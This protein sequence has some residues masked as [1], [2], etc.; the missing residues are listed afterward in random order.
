MLKL[1]DICKTYKSKKGAQFQRLF[2]YRFRLLPQY[3]RRIRISGIQ[4]SERIF[5]RG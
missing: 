3:F 2:V 5:G 1:K 4:H